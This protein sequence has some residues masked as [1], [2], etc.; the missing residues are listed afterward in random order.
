MSSLSERTGHIC[1][2]RSP[3]SKLEGSMK[4]ASSVCKHIWLVL[5]LTF[6]A[7][8]VHASKLVPAPAAIC[9]DSGFVTR[10]LLAKHL[11]AL[12][13]GSPAHQTVYTARSSDINDKT[14]M[15][16]MVTPYKTN[17][18][19]AASLFGKVCANPQDEGCTNA[20]RLY[21]FN[22]LNFAAYF[23]DA[24]T[25]DSNKSARTYEASPK[26]VAASSVDRARL[27]FESNDGDADIWI[28]CNARKARKPSPSPALSR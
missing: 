27:F 11:L 12:S 21:K 8:A 9:S 7:V 1:V 22:A 16:T 18:V 2:R 17:D 26:L 6:P 24:L 25:N 15:Q 5:A 3:W 19:C 20:C 4:F 14:L 28:S 10:Q 13:N 23:F